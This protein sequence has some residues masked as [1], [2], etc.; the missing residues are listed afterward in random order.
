MPHGHGPRASGPYKANPPLNGAIR[1]LA[2]NRHT[3]P[4]EGSARSSSWW[5]QSS[6][7]PP[8]LR[9]FPVP[10]LANPPSA[11][12]I[13]MTKH[14]EVFGDEDSSLAG[15]P[16]NTSTS[17][18]SSPC[19]VL[20]CLASGGWNRCR[21]KLNHLRSRGPSRKARGGVEQ[22]GATRRRRGAHA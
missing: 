3:P 1:R 17:A 5:A 18:F 10:P 13:G 4:R 12:G 8:A 2:T 15:I 14:L 19:L 16:E 7:I 9:H 22:G 21:R 11:P 20:W 6:P